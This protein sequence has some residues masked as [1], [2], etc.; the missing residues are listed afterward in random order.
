MRMEKPFCFLISFNIL[1]YF[2][3][4]IL[5]PAPPPSAP[6]TDPNT[7]ARL[8]FSSTRNSVAPYEKTIERFSSAQLPSEDLNFALI[9]CIPTS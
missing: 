7:I 1:T 9:A 8:L 4:L 6:H 2:N 5:S 3:S